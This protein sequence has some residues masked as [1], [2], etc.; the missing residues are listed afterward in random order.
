MNRLVF[1]HKRGHVDS[2]SKIMRCD[3]L[4]QIAREY[5]G[6]GWSFDVVGLP[7]FRDTD[8]LES[9]IEDLS[10]AVVVFLKRAYNVFSQE[11]LQRLGAKASKLVVDHVDAPTYPLPDYCFDMHLCASISGTHALR[12]QLFGPNAQAVESST[13]VETLIHHSDPRIV[14]GDFKNDVDLRLGYFGSSKNTRL[15]RGG[16]ES[17]RYDGASVSDAFLRSLAKANVHYA[18]RPTAPANPRMIYKPFTKGFNAAAAGAHVLVNRD[19]CDA[20]EHL[21]QDYPFFI[22]GTGEDDILA[23]IETLKHE[24]GGR[25]WKESFGAISHMRERSLPKYSARSFENILGRLMDS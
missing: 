8:A 18:V 14:W 3:Q 16:V 5:I 1:L 20:V 9:V 23:G 21:G 11:Q 13:R 2:G 17:P 7:H 10:G 6:G 24:M 22:D 15:P 4:C 12:S 25:V 19:V